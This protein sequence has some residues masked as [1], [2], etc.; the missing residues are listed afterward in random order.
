MHRWTAIAQ[1]LVEA[2][3]NLEALKMRFPRKSAW[4]RTHNQH[5]G[6]LNYIVFAGGLDYLVR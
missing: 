6:F 4:S 5:I 1:Q 2:A 3:H